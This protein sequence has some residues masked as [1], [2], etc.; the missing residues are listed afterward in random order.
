MRGSVL[1]QARAY[2]DSELSADDMLLPFAELPFEQPPALLVSELPQYEYSKKRFQR[3]LGSIAT[4]SSVEYGEQPKTTTLLDAINQTAFEG[5]KDAEALIDINVGTTVSEA[6]FKKE[7]VTSISMHLNEQGE[8]IQFGQTMSQ[9]QYNSLALRPKR[10]ERLEAVTRQEALNGHAIEDLANQGVLDDY[11]FVVSSLV[12]ENVPEGDLG[13]K[14]DGYFLHSLT[15]VNQATTRT[16][17]DVI[18]QP[19]FSEGTFADEEASFEERIAR[20]HDIQ[21]IS[22]VR[23]RLG[24][25]PISTTDEALEGI[26]VHKSLM[27]NGVVDFMRMCDEEADRILGR[28]ADRSDAYYT[29]LLANSIAKE[30]SLA[31]IKQQVKADLLQHAG[32]LED[33]MEAIQLLWELTK[34]HSVRSAAT[35]LHIDPIVFGQEAV[36]RVEESRYRLSMGDFIGAEMAIREALKVATI[37]GCGGGSSKDK[38][39]DNNSDSNNEGRTDSIASEREDSPEAWKWKTGVCRVE[40]CPSRPGK[41]KI[42]PC[43]VCKRCQAIFDRGSD[44]TKLK[45][46]RKNLEQKDLA[47]AA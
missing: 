20:R 18:T 13:E 37:S 6:C 35:N 47:L 23:Q 33:P 26:L 41:T 38:D 3:L 4:K 22:A 34:K 7:H 30:E 2:T 11:W 25:P 44:P 29:N 43:A 14:G 36:A 15:Y 46:I 42:G 39:G 8:L 31:D 1:E 32:K 24:L 19:A 10:H 16:G 12:P 45:P 21:T 28:T 5:S 40:V 9:F 17:D 27:P